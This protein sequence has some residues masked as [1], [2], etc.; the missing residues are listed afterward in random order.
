MKAIQ[1]TRMGAPDVLQLV[2]IETPVAGHGQVLI[3]VAAAGINFAETQ[4]R[5]GLYP[6]QLPLI[7][8]SEAA[9]TI[10]ALGPGVSGLAP[11][12]RVAAAF[13]QSGGYAEYALADAADVI[14]LPEQLDFPQATALFVQ[15]LTAY[16][17]AHEVAPPGS[18]ET[19]LVH[20]AAGGVGSLLVQLAKLRGAGKVIATASSASKLDLALRLGADV[21]INYTDVNWA[22]QVRATTGERG[23]DIIYEATSGA[24]GEQSFGLLGPRGRMVLYGLF[25]LQST[26]FTTAQVGQLIG[27]NQSILG[28]SISS[29]RATQPERLQAPL[30]ELFALAAEGALQ[31]AIGGV[32]PLSEAAAAHRALEQRATTGKLVLVP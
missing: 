5:Q 28:F 32:F 17:L 9:G 25:N 24:I 19:V 12:A 20:A 26:Q 3:K 7:M 18:G 1:M 16:L 27:Q 2:D 29:L 13:L 14:L 10:A 21:A 31:V 6:V 30:R 8:G 15:G 11:G 22:E 23:V 4:M